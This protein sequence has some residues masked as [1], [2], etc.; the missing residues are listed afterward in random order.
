MYRMMVF[1]KQE[2]SVTLHG[3]MG[4]K[5]TRIPSRAGKDLISHFRSLTAGASLSSL[6]FVHESDERIESLARL[7]TYEFAFRTA[8]SVFPWFR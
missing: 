6:R 4:I 8:N 1:I 5:T 3:R 7:I 2:Y